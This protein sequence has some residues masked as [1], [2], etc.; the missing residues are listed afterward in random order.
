[1]QQSLVFYEMLK[2][3]GTKIKLTAEIGRLCDELTA[4]LNA[5]ADDGTLLLNPWNI[6]ASSTNKNTIEEPGKNLIGVIKYE[7]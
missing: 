3:R 2:P 7:Y 4:N 1:M 5:M 6:K